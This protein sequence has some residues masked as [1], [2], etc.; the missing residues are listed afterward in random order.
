MQWGNVLFD[1]AEIDFSEME[2]EI[3]NTADAQL[4]QLK[5]R[6]LDGD[7]EALEF[8]GTAYLCGSNGLHA[9]FN[10][11]VF[12]FRLAAQGGSTTAQLY[13]GDCCAYGIGMPVDADAARYY[14][15]LAAQSTIPAV[16]DAALEQL[17][18]LE[19]TQ[20]ETV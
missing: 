14:Y 3:L 4:I 2:K 15:R 17:K 19:N 11:A 12:L 18:K 7:T 8:I 5:Q 6:L 9:D 13:I 1:F 16:R 20:R 10:K